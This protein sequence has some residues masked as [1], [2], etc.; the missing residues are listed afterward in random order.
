MK[1]EGTRSTPSVSIENGIID[2]RGRSIPEDS[3][4]FY[5]PIVHIIQEYL[6]DPA[7]TTELHF[8]LEYI[9]SGSKKYITN[10]L[11][12]FNELYLHGKDV[13]VYW[14]YDIDD[15]SMLELGNDLQSIIDIPFNLNVVE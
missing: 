11:N 12:Y 10:I 9:N 1:I 6:K 13:K 4:D 5:S 7:E 15:E 2:I 14:N 8:Q 3:H